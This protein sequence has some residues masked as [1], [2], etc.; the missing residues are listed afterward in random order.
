[1]SMTKVLALTC[2]A[3]MACCAEASARCSVP[4]IHTLNNQTVDGQM[5]VSS[6][7]RCSIKLK[8]SSGPTYGAHIVQRASNGTVTVDGSNRVVYRSRA[9]YVGSDSFTYARTGES[10]VGNASTRTVRISVTVTP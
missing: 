4:R 3:L 7:A 8:H 9:G 5:T 1:M 2:L 10:R 6:G